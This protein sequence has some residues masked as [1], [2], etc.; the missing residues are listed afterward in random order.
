MSNNVP[1]FHCVKLLLTRA[2]LTCAA[3]GSGGD[4]ARRGQ[5][6]DLQGVSAVGVGGE[7]ADAP[8]SS[9]RSPERGPGGLCSGSGCHHSSPALHA[10]STWQVWFD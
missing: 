3:G 9:V 1:A 6:S 8:G 7:S 5:G 4:V 10:V 2:F